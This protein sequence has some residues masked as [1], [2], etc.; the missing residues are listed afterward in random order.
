[1][2]WKNGI[3]R[4]SQSWRSDSE[5]PSAAAICFALIREDRVTS[6]A[7]RPEH[8]LRDACAVTSQ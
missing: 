4:Q 1:M 3:W 6:I 2:V 7:P 5:L 8:K